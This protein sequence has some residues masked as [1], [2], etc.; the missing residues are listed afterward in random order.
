MPHQS[1]PDIRS[2]LVA[3][4]LLFGA[5]VACARPV[6]VNRSALASAPLS[7]HAPAAARPSF[8]TRPGVACDAPPLYWPVA[9]GARTLTV[10][11]DTR[12]AIAPVAASAER[13]LA[14]AIAEWNDVRL[15]IELARAAGARSADIRVVLRDRLPVESA[16]DRWRAGSTELVHTERGEIAQATVVLALRAPDGTPYADGDRAVVM[17]HE[18]GHALGLPHVEDRTTLMAPRPAGWGITRRDAQ[19][20][21]AQYAAAGTC[22]E[23]AR[24]ASRE[25]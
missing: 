9:T 15:P 16:D 2:L 4:P 21:R 17:L 12:A 23:S 14:E 6:T 24:L 1:F 19:V 22:R 20:A 13:L 7:A 11:L 10:S 8:A 5:T 18:L 25:E 3:A